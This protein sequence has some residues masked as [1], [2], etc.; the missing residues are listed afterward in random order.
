MSTEEILK[1]NK[2][3]STEEILQDITDTQEEIV[4]M[5]IEAE[6]LAKTPLSLQSARW[7]HMRADA[8][9]RLA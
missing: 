4:K 9:L 8:R 3:I 1:N 5:K 7:D 2:D 6:H